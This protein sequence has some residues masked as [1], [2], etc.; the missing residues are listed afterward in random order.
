MCLKQVFQKVTFLDVFLIN[1]HF[2]FV[3]NFKTLFFSFQFSMYYYSDT[4]D[5]F[6]SPSSKMRT[7]NIRRPH[8]EF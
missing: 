5:M 8:F 2:P 6:V 1:Y 4:F 7:P 3:F